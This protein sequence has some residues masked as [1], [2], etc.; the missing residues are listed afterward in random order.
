MRGQNFVLTPEEMEGTNERATISYKQLANDVV[1]SSRILIDD[2]LIELKVRGWR[3]TETSS[4]LVANG[5]FISNNK[6]INV[7]GV[8]LSLPFVSPKDESDILFAIR[9]GF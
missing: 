5:G 2:G 4:A 7:P 3:R 8:H 1:P 9:T 6:G